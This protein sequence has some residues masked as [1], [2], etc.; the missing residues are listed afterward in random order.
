M[1]SDTNYR[2]GA[3]LIVRLTMVKNNNDENI[4]IQPDRAR[5]HVTSR[6]IIININQRKIKQKLRQSREEEG[7]RSLGREE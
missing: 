1:L 4:T 7:C 5:M 2:H 6:V 3:Y